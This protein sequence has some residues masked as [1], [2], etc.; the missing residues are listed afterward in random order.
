MPRRFILQLARGPK[1][2][3]AG[4]PEPPEPYWRC[5]RCLMRR[6]IFQS[7]SRPPG[8][9]CGKCKSAVW[10]PDTAAARA[11]DKKNGMDPSP[12]VPIPT[13]QALVAMQT[14]EHAI[15]EGQWTRYVVASE[16]HIRTKV[17]DELRRAMKDYDLVWSL[18]F[19][20]Q[21]AELRIPFWPREQ[22]RHSSWVRSTF[23]EPAFVV[24]YRWVQ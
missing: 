1:R 13:A 9:G 11:L 6:T 14:V 16:P 20:F 5:S 22:N 17:S 10:M 4:V 19:D 12:T 18:E 21:A 23:V 3:P 2:T 24:A 7:Q 15:A 8:A